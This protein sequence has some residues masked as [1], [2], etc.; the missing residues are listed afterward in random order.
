MP[1]RLQLADHLQHLADQ[2]GVEG[3]G[4][5]VEQQRPRPRGQRADDRHALLLAAGEPVGVV[6]LAAA[7]PEPR[8]QLAAARPSASRARRPCARTGASDTF[9]STLRCGNRLN[10]WKT[11][12]SRR[13]TADG[14]TDGSVTTSPSSKHVAVVDLL[15]QVDAAQQRRLARAGGADQRHRLVL[16]RPRG[17]CRAAPAAR[18]RPWS[19]RAPRAPARAHGAPRRLRRRARACR[20][21]TIRASGTVTAR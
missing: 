8:E 17:R 12:P 18:R 7:Q 19:R 20:R 21:S 5:L 4:D 13:R 10:A 2:L 9:S 11:I 6:V 14:S 16:A 1:S 3:A 15:E